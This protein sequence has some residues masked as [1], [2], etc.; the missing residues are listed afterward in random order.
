MAHTL[1]LTLY[2][3]NSYQ[4]QSEEQR[5]HNKTEEKRSLL[6]IDKEH[7]LNNQLSHANKTAKSTALSLWVESACVMLHSGGRNSSIYKHITGYDHPLS[8]GSSWALLIS[9]DTPGEK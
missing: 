6:D 4:A 5:S 2:P 7:V 9:I 3:V 8:L 1:K